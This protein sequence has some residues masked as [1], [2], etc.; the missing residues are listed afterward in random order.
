MALRKQRTR[1]NGGKEEKG[2]MKRK[3][4]ENVCKEK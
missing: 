1:E 2:S 3:G 4:K